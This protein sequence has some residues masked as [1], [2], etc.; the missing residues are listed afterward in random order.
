M[1]PIT[2]TVGTLIHHSPVF[3]T[4][5]T[6]SSH[7]LFS[8]HYSLLHSQNSLSALNPCL[9]YVERHIID[10][11]MNMCS[12][13]FCCGECVVIVM[14]VTVIVENLMTYMLPVAELLSVGR[15]PFERS[16][17]ASLRFNKEKKKAH[18]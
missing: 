14:V 4:I 1:K 18:Q 11:Y 10:V 17:W 2:L 9:R 8:P 15:E 5:S 12:N 16:I 13:E 6:T 7:G 3:P